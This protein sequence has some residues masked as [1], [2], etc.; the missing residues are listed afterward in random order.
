M[1]QQYK[2]GE[3]SLGYLTLLA[4][5]CMFAQKSGN[6]EL[7]SEIGLIIKPLY[8]NCMEIFNEIPK[9]IMNQMRKIN[10]NRMINDS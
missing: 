7:M 5:Y 2:F 3:E 8:D 4:N 6:K 1:V 10:L 9:L